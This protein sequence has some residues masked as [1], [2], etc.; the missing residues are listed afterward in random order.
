MPF[1][2]RQC[3]DTTDS[4]RG[5]CKRKECHFAWGL[6]HLDPGG[7]FF[8]EQGNVGYGRWR[9]TRVALHFAGKVLVFKRLDIESV[10]TATDFRCMLDNPTLKE[11]LE[12]LEKEA[13]GVVFETPS[14][15]C[16]CQNLNPSQL[17]PEPRRSHPAS[18]LTGPSFRQSYIEPKSLGSTDPSSGA[19][20]V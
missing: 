1:L 11:G 18:P 13:V 10:R 17:T 2:S 19:A 5:R 9:I 15:L 14:L 7:T 16:Q 3:L 12:I 4:V 8:W 20:R 6:A